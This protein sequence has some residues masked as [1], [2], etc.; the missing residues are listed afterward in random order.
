MYDMS[1]NQSAPAISTRR[2]FV[3]CVAAT[4]MLPWL[5]AQAQDSSGVIRLGQTTAL[6]G[7][8]GEL[9]Q[10]LV[11]G[12]KSYLQQVNVREGVHGRKIELISLDDAYDA[13]KALNNLNVLLGEKD[14]F[15]L[16]NCLGTPIVEAILPK[17]TEV[18]IP[19]FAPYTGALVARPK[20]RNVFNIRPSFADEAVKLVQHLST[21][22]IN[23]IGL[24]Y[25]NNAFGREVYEGARL[26]MEKYKITLSSAATVEN[27]GADAAMAATKLLGYL[28][29]AVVMG[30]AGKPTVDFVKAVR[31]QHKG[32]SLYALSILGASSTLKSLGD[33]G[34]GIIVSQVVPS[35]T[36]TSVAVVRDY[37]QAW[38]E[39]GTTL[40]MSHVGLEGYINARVF[41]EALRRAGPKPTREGFIDAT[42]DLK[43]LDLGGFELSPTEPG[44]NASRF[45]E[46]T[47]VNRQGRFIK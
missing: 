5:A 27:T 46:M 16:F 9:G 3:Q 8:L 38:I 10:A 44:R 19:F 39:S 33:D 22:G 6:S 7:P 28:P 29:Q 35:P 43:R 15:A 26:A 18:G 45:I 40:E 13:K 20:Q 1:M 30:L 4:S 23:R 17:V 41:I 2:H 31:R 24:V 11:Q 25:H 14:V 34:V 37:Q 42:W 32:L 21:M 36:S 47:M 12:A